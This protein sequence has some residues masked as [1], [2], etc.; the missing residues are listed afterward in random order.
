M[1]RLFTLIVVFILI[2]VLTLSLFPGFFSKEDCTYVEAVQKFA[3]GK[4]VTVDG[5]KVHYIE[6]GNGAP[7]ILIHGFL[8]HTVMWKKNIDAL[9]EKFKVYA[10]D[11]WGFGY[12]ERLP[13]LDYGFP[14]FGRQIKGFMEALGI[15]RATL[16]G[17][18]MGGGIAVYVAAH[19]PDKVDR[20]ILVDPAVIPYPDTIVATIYKLPGVG[21]FLNSLPGDFV[22]KNNLKNFWF[23][24]PR[25]VTDEYAAEVLQP[26]C[27]QGSHEALMYI[28]RNV[29]KE[30]LVE[31]EARQL[32]QTNLP[33]LLIH[34]REDKAV[35]LNRSRALNKLWKSSRL[36]IFE[37]SGHSPEEEHPEQF[38]R[39]AMEFLL[40]KF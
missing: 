28:L 37:R 18:S 35:P 10:I 40:E 24:D 16:V 36:V 23:Y 14:L 21:E 39:V 6:K 30:P 33:I 1:G 5:K 11:L 31:K 25:K 17:Q 13:Q 38:N 4:F 27:I 20:L 3:K 32:A 12:S 29:L 34:G 8:Y 22:M 26:L 2:F 15:P 7:L 19:Y 9:A